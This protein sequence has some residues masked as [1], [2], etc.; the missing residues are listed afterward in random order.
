MKMEKKISEIK[1]L[2][3]IISLSKANKNIKNIQILKVKNQT[4]IK[5]HLTMPNKL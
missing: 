2:S 4:G 1:R 5:L 3:K